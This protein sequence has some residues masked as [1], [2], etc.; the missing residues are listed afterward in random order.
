MLWHMTCCD[1]TIHDIWHKNLYRGIPSRLVINCQSTNVFYFRSF[2]VCL[3]TFSGLCK[4]LWI[5]GYKEGQYMVVSLCQTAFFAFFGVAE[6]RVWSALHLL[7]ILAPPPRW[8]VLIMENMICYCSIVT[9]TISVVLYKC[10]SLKF[11]ACEKWKWGLLFQWTIS[12]WKTLYE[13]LVRE[14]A[15]SLETVWKRNE[16]N[17]QHASEDILPG[18]LA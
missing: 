7:L 12:K 17:Q 8:G 16:H 2:V 15:S 10:V 9:R 6:K 13:Y 14:A 11:I 5:N 18:G 4:L 1:I 3:Y